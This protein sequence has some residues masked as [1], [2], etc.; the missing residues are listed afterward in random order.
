MCICAL[1]ILEKA[2]VVFRTCTSLALLTQTNMQTNTV[3]LFS[4]PTYLLEIQTSEC[5]Y[6]WLDHSYAYI[7]HYLHSHM[8]FSIGSERSIEIQILHFKHN[9]LSLS[10]IFLQMIVNLRATAYN[11]FVW[12]YSGT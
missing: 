12:Q 11:P 2:N 8:R 4:K 3:N 10:V 1:Y 7:W 6:L 5:I 9:L